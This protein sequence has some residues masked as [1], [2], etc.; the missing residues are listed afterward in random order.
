MTKNA[1]ALCKTHNEMEFH[2]DVLTS[3][4]NISCDGELSLR[5]QKDKI[6]RLT[7]DYQERLHDLAEHSIA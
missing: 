6:K 2:W 4:E 5:S 1:F 3:P 7:K